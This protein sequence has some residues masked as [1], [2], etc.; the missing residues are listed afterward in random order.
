MRPNEYQE[1]AARTLIDKP[2]VEIPDLEIMLVW[3]AIGL[4]G[5]AGEK[6]ERLPNSLRNRFS[7]STVS[8]AKSGKR[9]WATCFGMSPDARPNS[10]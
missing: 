6:P 4:A 2:D 1:K 10:D 5:E 7:I 9:N 8:T 3:N